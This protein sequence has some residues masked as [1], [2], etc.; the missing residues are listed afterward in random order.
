MTHLYLKPRRG[1]A[2][3]SSESGKVMRPNV[4][5]C[6]G[7]EAWSR[8]AATQ[9][10]RQPAQH[11]HMVRLATGCS[12]PV[13]LHGAWHG[14]AISRQPALVLSY[15]LRRTCSLSSTSQLPHSQFPGSCCSS[16]RRLVVRR[17]PWRP[18]R[19]SSRNA[20][21]VLA[22]LAAVGSS[23]GGGQS[24]DDAEE[25]G[26]HLG[27]NLCIRCTPV[28]RFTHCACIDTVII[29]HPEAWHLL[30]HSVEA[31]PGGRSTWITKL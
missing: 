26:C 14:T 17:S 22:P 13:L 27:V 7:S 30:Q 10:H 23:S 25:V 28:L 24:M 9:I 21:T 4:I 18:G 2:A 19:Q 20:D 1:G 5:V 6:S 3:P 16:G 12:A 11:A 15:P 8:G 29:W 31:L